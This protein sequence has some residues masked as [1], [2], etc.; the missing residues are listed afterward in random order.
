[1]EPTKKELVLAACV[2]LALPISGEV[3][4][5]VMHFQYAAQLYTG[6]QQRG[7]ALRPGAEGVVVDEVR[8]YVSINSHGFRDYERSY[9]KPPNTVRIA[10]LGNSWTEALQVPL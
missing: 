3:F 9:E 6:D 8:Q 4:F 10:V 7:W 2:L 5:R 1:M